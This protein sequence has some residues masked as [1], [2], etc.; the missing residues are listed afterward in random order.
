MATCSDLANDVKY[1]A[2]KLEAIRSAVSRLMI[3]LDET[4]CEMF[5]GMA[6]LVFQDVIN[7]VRLIYMALDPL[8]GEIEK[9]SGKLSKNVDYI[10]DQLV[11]EYENKKADAPTSTKEK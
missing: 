10:Y 6:Q 5:G 4:E 3:Q 8:V 1:G 11:D 7:K 2:I 9:D